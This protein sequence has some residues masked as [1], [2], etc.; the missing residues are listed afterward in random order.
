MPSSVLY[1]EIC[2]CGYT[3][4]ISI[5]RDYVGSLLEVKS[6]AGEE[7]RVVQN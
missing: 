2:E 1:R 3:G 5:V 4:K 7:A 6:S